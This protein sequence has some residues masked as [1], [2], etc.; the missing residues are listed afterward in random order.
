[1]KYNTGTESTTNT[2]YTIG[3]KLHKHDIQVDLASV[4]GLDT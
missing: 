2:P 4:T 1:M 3:I